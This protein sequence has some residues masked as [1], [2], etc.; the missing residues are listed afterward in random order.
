MILEQF[1]TFPL[2]TIKLTYFATSTPKVGWIFFSRN[3]FLFD[4]LFFLLF[5][6]TL[7]LTSGLYSSLSFN[8]WRTFVLS[9]YT[10]FF[11]HSL[12]KQTQTFSA[13][14][15]DL[16]D[17]TNMRRRIDIFFLAKFDFNAFFISN[18]FI[19]N[20]SLKLAIKQLL[21][22]TLRLNFCYLKVILIFH[23][24]YHPKKQYMK[25]VKEEV[26]L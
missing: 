13:R 8:Q 9:E 1:G 24:R 23:P 22:N 2:F 20:A 6:D 11:M 18:T 12:L 17:V 7:L 16:C 21:S 4:N 26:C 15:A 10:H 19:S 14:F 5:L 25:E 3:I